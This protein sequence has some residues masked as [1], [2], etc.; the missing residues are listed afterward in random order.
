MTAERG[1]PDGN[2]GG[3]SRSGWKLETTHD[4]GGHPALHCRMA[5]DLDQ[6][7]RLT[8]E[9][10]EFASA[11]DPLQAQRVCLAIDELL[12]NV[13]QYGIEPG[14]PAAIQ[15]KVTLRE[16]RILIRIEHDGVPFNPFVEAATPN[17]HLPLEERPIGGLG[18]FLVKSLMTSTLYE[19]IGNRNRIT[20][21]RS[22]QGHGRQGPPGEAP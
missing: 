9:V 11:A 2:P 15:L 3:S 13:I 20:L 19:R 22:F 8:E 18:V 5:P 12:T 4:E 7:S 17:I 6:L 14:N 21:T 16:D 1:V 10:E